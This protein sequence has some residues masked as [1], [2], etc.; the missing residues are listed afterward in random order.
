[1]V[2]EKMEGCLVRIPTRA[3]GKYS[4]AAVVSSHPPFLVWRWCLAVRERANP[5]SPLIR[6]ND[7]A[8]AA[9]MAMEEAGEVICNSAKRMWVGMPGWRGLHRIA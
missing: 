9:A 7:L 3:C 8:S 5:G 4:I 6:R 1:M 2:R